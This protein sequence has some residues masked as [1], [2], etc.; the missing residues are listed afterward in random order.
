MYGACW[1]TPILPRDEEFHHK[2]ATQ[3]KG[4]QIQ[5]SLSRIGCGELFSGGWN[6]RQ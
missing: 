3:E 6:Q 2:E 5:G 1:C 4:Y